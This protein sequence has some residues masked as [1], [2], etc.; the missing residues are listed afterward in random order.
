MIWLLK[1]RVRFAEVAAPAV[2][3]CRKLAMTAAA[4]PAAAVFWLRSYTLALGRRHV[5][6]A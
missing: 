1:V 6:M 2:G 4:L 5:S 3:C